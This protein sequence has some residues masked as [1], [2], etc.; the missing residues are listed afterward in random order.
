MTARTAFVALAAGL[1][2]LGAVGAATAKPDRPDA[3]TGDQG[4]L[5]GQGADHRANR[6]GKEMKE[7]REAARKDR[8]HVFALVEDLRVHK[9]LLNR[10]E[11]RIGRVQE[12]LAAGNL[13]G[14]QTQELQDRLQHLERFEQKLEAKIAKIEGKLQDLRARWLEHRRGAGLGKGDDDLK[15]DGAADDASG[16]GATTTSPTSAA[17]A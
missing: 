3:A 13:T 16:E 10:T 4:R 1:L 11:A 2:V 12:R 8:R 14:N 7:L 9:R 6:T 15:G 5:Q 17:A